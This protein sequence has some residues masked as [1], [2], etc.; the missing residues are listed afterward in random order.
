MEGLEAARK[1]KK[2]HHKVGVN[3]LPAYDD[4]QFVVEAVRSGAR[5]YVLKARDAEHLIQTVRLV[6]GGDL[7]I[8]PQLVVALAEGLLTAKGA[9]RQA[10]TPRPPYVQVL[11]PPAF[12]P[13]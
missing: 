7:V 11:Q 10:G 6:A 13:P 8:H 12:R 5:G 9:R 1:I 2:G 3:M 4:R